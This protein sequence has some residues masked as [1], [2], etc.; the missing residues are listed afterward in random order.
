VKV[1]C[2]APALP[3]AMEASPIDSVGRTTGGGLSPA[4]LRTSPDAAVPPAP[5]VAW[6]PKLAWPP[7]GT[8][9]FQSRLRIT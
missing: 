8:F 7:A 1:S 4:P 3:S 6:K 2:D 9:E 5:D